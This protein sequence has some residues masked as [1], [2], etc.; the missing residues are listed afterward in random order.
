MIKTYTTSVS[1]ECA[2]V[3]NSSDDLFPKPGV[4]TKLSMT[5]S[6]CTVL[7]TNTTDISV[8]GGL[9]GLELYTLDGGGVT[10]EVDC[11]W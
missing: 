3:S 1:I 4:N 6:P 5:I 2:N 11:T 10:E 8:V 9:N 7:G